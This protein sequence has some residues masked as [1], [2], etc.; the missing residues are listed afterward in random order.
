MSNPGRATIS[1][2]IRLSELPCLRPRNAAT[3]GTARFTLVELIVVITIIAALAGMLLPVASKSRARSM[4]AACG[5][6]M[7]QIGGGMLM[8]ADDNADWYINHDAGTAQTWATA[9]SGNMDA[10]FPDYMPAAVT[11]CPSLPA[12]PTDTYM[13]MVIV[14][15]QSAVWD[16][17]LYDQ[18]SVR[19]VGLYEGTDI[20]E[21]PAD[22]PARVLAGDLMYGYDG[23]TNYTWTQAA[24]Q[25]E[26]S[27]AH[28][29]RV[30]NSV[31]EDGHVTEFSTG[32]D[33]VPPSYAVWNST[34]NYQNGGAFFS[35]AWAAMPSVGVI[36]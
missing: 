14:A 5:N 29:G 30:S 4:L 34:W 35:N 24:G 2:G 25:P 21:V 3:G 22:A 11:A 16:L 23:L 36:Q 27:V 10:F 32:I 28:Q 8:Y 7:K 15:G 12:D 6:N 17:M 33:F 18:V 26:Y 13:G 31:F 9:R 1:E 19:K 20:A